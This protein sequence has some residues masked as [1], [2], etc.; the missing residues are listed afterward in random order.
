MHDVVRSASL[1]LFWR[2]EAEA[3]TGRI[4][5]LQDEVPEV[6]RHLLPA[7]A[8]VM[9]VQNH[10]RDYDRNRRNGHHHRQV[11]A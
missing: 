9:E 4:Y 8:T 11:D 7:G 3:G 2:S 6:G 1:L 10:N 5:P